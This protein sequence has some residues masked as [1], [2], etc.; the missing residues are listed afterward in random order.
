MDLLKNRN[1]RDKNNQELIKDI[2]DDGLIQRYRFGSL[3]EMSLIRELILDKIMKEKLKTPEDLKKLDKIKDQLT[4]YF[5]VEKLEQIDTN[6]YI[7][8]ITFTE[9]TFEL[10]TGGLYVNNKDNY[11]ILKHGFEMEQKKF[12]KISD[13]TPIFCKLTDEDKM[14]MVL[15]EKLN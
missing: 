3:A 7:R 10:K 9:D 4:E 14:L 8:Y 13:K 1:Q 6:D 2:L 15:M 12:W 11:V 5:Y